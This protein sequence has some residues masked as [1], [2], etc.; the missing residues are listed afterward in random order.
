ML[1]STFL[2]KHITAW[3]S[4]QYLY[5]EQ[6]I[7]GYLHAVINENCDDPAFIAHALGVV[8]RARSTMSQLSRDT[9]V[10]RDM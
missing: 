10:S 7:A 5:T 2:N 9:G 3:D 4:A 8:A 1:L 6:D